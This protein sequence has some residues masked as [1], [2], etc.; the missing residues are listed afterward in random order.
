MLT[1]RQK[2]CGLGEGS[3]RK[4]GVAAVRDQILGDL[5]LTFFDTAWYL[6]LLVSILKVKSNNTLVTDRSIG[7]ALGQDSEF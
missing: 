1:I 6:F 5:D 2:E 4:R 7:N 3:N